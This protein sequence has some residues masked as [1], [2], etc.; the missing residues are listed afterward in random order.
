LTEALVHMESALA[1]LEETDGPGD[2]AAHL[3]LAI[4][5]L[6]DFLQPGFEKKVNLL[7]E[8]PEGSAV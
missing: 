6:D 4:S 8:P 3:D 7:D 5:R 2:V 1:I